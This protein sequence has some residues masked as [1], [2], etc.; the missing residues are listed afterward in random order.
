ML[1]LFS[2]LGSPPRKA[3]GRRPG[4]PPIPFAASC[5]HSAALSGERSLPPYHLLVS[6][7]HLRPGRGLL[8]LAEQHQLVLREGD[9][10]TGW[11]RNRVKRGPVSR[12]PVR[13]P[14]QATPAAADHREGG[15]IIKISPSRQGNAIAPPEPGK[16]RPWQREMSGRLRSRAGT[17][18]QIIQHADAYCDE[19]TKRGGGT[20]TFQRVMFSRVEAVKLSTRTRS[21][22]ASISRRS[23]RTG[24]TPT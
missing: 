7:R 9:C 10:L 24:H 17:I 1:E 22:L 14:H 2:N 13:P 12:R 21:R 4:G 11:L 8:C 15:R 19:Q 18:D 6:S 5:W 3:A 16:N 23:L 20:K